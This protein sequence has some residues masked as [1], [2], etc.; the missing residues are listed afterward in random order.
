[1]ENIVVAVLLKKMYFYLFSTSLLWLT[2]KT[3]SIK[4]KY[5]ACSEK[6]AEFSNVYKLCNASGKYEA[7]G[8]LE[9]LDG[10]GGTRGGRFGYGLFG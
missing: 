5:T 8:Y 2:L 3:L 7:R 6:V 1:M 9:S 4:G 10:G